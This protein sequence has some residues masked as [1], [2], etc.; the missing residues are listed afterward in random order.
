MPRAGRTLSAAA[1]PCRAVQSSTEVPD[2][3]ARGPERIGAGSEPD[4]RRVGTGSAP[5]GTESAPR[6]R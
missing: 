1:L 5:I 2:F 6:E 3:H 4:R